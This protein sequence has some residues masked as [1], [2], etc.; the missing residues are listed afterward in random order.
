MDTNGRKR[1]RESSDTIITYLAPNKTFE[2][3]LKETSLDE[4]RQVVRR[5]LN[6]A[7]NESI[8]LAQLRSGRVIDLDDDG[9]F[10]AFRVTA[11]MSDSVDVRVSIS[12]NCSSSIPTP[13]DSQT[14]SPALPSTAMAAPNEDIVP[15]AA[16]KRKVVFDDLAVSSSSDSPVLP[17]RKRRKSISNSTPSV[18]YTLGPPTP[19]QLDMQPSNP[20]DSTTISITSSIPSGGTATV[21]E[22]PNNN[23][24]LEGGPEAVTTQ[25]DGTSAVSTREQRTTQEEGG[26]GD[27]DKRKK[28]TK[29][30]KL[31][32]PENEARDTSE[33]LEALNEASTNRKSNKKFP[34]QLAEAMNSATNSQDEGQKGPDDT[35]PGRRTARRKSVS[36]FIEPRPSTVTSAQKNLQKGTTAEIPGEAGKGRRKKKKKQAAVVGDT[37]T[38]DI[39]SEPTAKN[40][41]ETPEPSKKAQTKKSMKDTPSASPSKLA[42]ARA[43]LANIIHRNRSMPPPSKATP[44]TAEKRTSSVPPS[45]GDDDAPPPQKRSDSRRLGKA[46]LTTQTNPNLGSS[47]AQNSIAN[48]DDSDSSDDEPVNYMPVQTPSSQKSAPIAFPDVDLDTLIRGPN[49]RRLTLDNALLASAQTSTPADNVSLE[50]DVDESQKNRKRSVGRSN[51]SDSEDGDDDDSSSGKERVEDAEGDVNMGNENASPKP[52]ET[53]HTNLHNNIDEA[54]K[55]VQLAQTASQNISSPASRSVVPLEDLDPIQPVVE[56]PRAESPIEVDSTQ[57]DTAKPPSSRTRSRQASNLSIPKPKPPSTQTLARASNTQPLSIHEQGVRESIVKMTRSRAKQPVSSQPKSLDNNA[58]PAE[59]LVDTP[60]QAAKSV[61]TAVT[62]AGWTTLQSPPSSSR[63]P[64]ETAGLDELRSSSQPLFDDNDRSKDSHS[65]P[66]FIA[67]ESQAQFPYSQWQDDVGEADSDD[68]EEVAQAITVQ[69]RTSRTTS[70]RRLTD[71]ASQH[72]LF[73]APLSQPIEPQKSTTDMYGEM[74]DVY[75]DDSETDSD[76]DVEKSHIPRSR[77]A[78]A[79]TR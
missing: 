2:R 17:P 66:L 30:K 8:Q 72:T 19:S 3:L 21:H 41:G 67:S 49:K 23:H 9:D 18:R 20:E 79:K 69:S 40:R 51:W 36:V 24:S 74:A 61:A 26:P 56:V 70:F 34:E 14:L 54:R 75:G 22:P 12:S 1:K 31:P 37:V 46:A 29:A 28:K 16:P 4:I 5:K 64:S 35:T 42:S 59:P 27:G 58:N 76:S 77:R 13:S 43:A 73:S 25:N 57:D 32:D 71:I 63:S 55:P 78:G 52:P 11:S 15:S 6:L 38:Q 45:K 68:E 62:P 47:D 33:S 53:L 50:E 65:Q 10:D 7:D 39:Q 60:M 48:I 44:G